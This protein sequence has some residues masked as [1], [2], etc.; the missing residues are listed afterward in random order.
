M[1][2]SVKDIFGGS[3]DFANPWALLFLLLVP[4]GYW[5]M[6]RF[7]RATMLYTVTR[8]FK[9]PNRRKSFRVS[10]WRSVPHLWAIAIVL[11]SLAA[12][13]PQAGQN[14]EKV[15]TQGIDIVMT[16]DISSSMYAV[17]FKPKNRIQAAKIEAANFIEGRENDRIGLVIF[18]SKAFPQCPLTIDHNVLLELLK[19][20]DIGMIDDG[21]AI[22][23]AIITAGNRL[24]KSKAKSKVIILLTDG[25]NNC[26]RIDPETAAQACAA[27][28]A[29]IYAIG[30]GKRGKALYP[31]KDTFGNTRYVPMDVEIDEQTLR[32]IADATGGKYFRAT[33]TKK[34]HKIYQEI[35]KM[36][37]T[38]IEVK[39][40]KR[41]KEL[42]QFPLFLGF[43]F[44]AMA[45]VI[46]YII[47]RP[48]P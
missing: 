10:L 2:S 3:I 13:R 43:L 1:F 18:A 37:K 14:I 47:V 19:Q 23:D 27:I 6:K 41:Y 29:K 11:F 46:E 34:L 20:V 26:G 22:G 40:Y 5:L 8:R 32:E 42:F 31:M 24:R 12:A 7:P 16:L 25:R 45:I 39:R 35:D 38:K 21:T 30:M 33:D 4:F 28:G 9:K 44:S 48:I 15:Y 17:D 36:E